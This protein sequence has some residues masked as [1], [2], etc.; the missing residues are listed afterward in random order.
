MKIPIPFTNYELRLP[1]LK[2]SAGKVV[3]G[4]RA[5]LSLN[6]QSLIVNR[7]SER[8]MALVITLIMLS[9]TLIMAIAFLAISRRER[10]S[11]ASSNDSTVARFGNDTGLAAA[12][13][14]ILANILTT[15]TALYDYTLLVSTNY[16]NPY[17]YVIGSQSPTNVNYVYRSDGLPLNGADFD[18]NVANLLILPRAP[19]W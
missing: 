17:G 1:I 16:I 15:N 10:V 8:G 7:Q 9:V 19:S 4:R 13:S 14:Q 6:R 18:Q 3:T 11:V 2:K 12:E 5:G